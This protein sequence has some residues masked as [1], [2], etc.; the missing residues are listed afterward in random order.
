[1]RNRYLA[2]FGALLRAERDFAANAAHELRTPVAAARA[3]AQLLAG[4]PEATAEAA[5]IVAALD[6]ITA[7]TERL[8]QLTRAEAGVGLSR[9]P[10]DLARNQRLAKMYRSTSRRHS[11]ARVALFGVRVW[12]SGR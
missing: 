7:L 12:S 5:R 2:R 6:R 1:M 9:A 10:V 8:L 4:R 11:A 3:E